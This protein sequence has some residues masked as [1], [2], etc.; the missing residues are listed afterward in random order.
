MSSISSHLLEF[1]SW[2]AVRET[3]FFGQKSR[4]SNDIHVSHEVN[5]HRAH[6]G[7]A[8]RC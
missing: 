8:R 7:I 2:C 5:A 3:Y 4:G 6:L 1:E